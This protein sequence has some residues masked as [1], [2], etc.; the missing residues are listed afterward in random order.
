MEKEPNS[1]LYDY[2]LP[3]HEILVW[4]WL[5]DLSLTVFL[6]HHHANGDNKPRG[7]LVNGKGLPRGFYDKIGQNEVK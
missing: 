1:K 3:E 6:K 2:D 4:D 5:E 7:I